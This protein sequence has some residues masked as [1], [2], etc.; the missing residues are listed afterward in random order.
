MATKIF[1]GNVGGGKSYAAVQEVMSCLSQGG[2]VATNL[3]L[4]W[5]TIDAQ[6]P[7]WKSRITKLPRKLTS[8]VKMAME[9]DPET[10]EDIEVFQ[11][12][13]ATR[14]TEG[15][16]NLIVIDEASL[17]LN[18]DD[19]ASKKDE[20]KPLF[21][22]SA[23]CRHGGLDL[24]YISQSKAN[25]D[26]KIRRM[27]DRVINCVSVKR[28]PLV[29]WFLVRFGDFI[30]FHYEKDDPKPF[31]RSWHRF[32]KKVGDF[33]F[34]HGMA[35][36]LKLKEAEGVRRKPE[37]AD[38]KRGKMLFAGVALLL[39]VLGWYIWHNTTDIYA[40]RFG[41]EKPSEKPSAVASDDKKTP[42]VKSEVSKS[43]STV[44]KLPAVLGLPK[45]VHD[46]PY[47]SVVWSGPVARKVFLGDGSRLE[48]GASWRGQKVL[49]LLTDADLIFVALS[50]GFKLCC[51]PFSREEIEERRPKPAAKVGL[52]EGFAN[53]LGINPNEPTK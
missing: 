37:D 10:G 16:E 8:M 2:Y 24:I 46:V 12:P 18:V 43:A 41:D 28:I 40:R 42:V 50:G 44:G 38:Q 21:A 23:L 53:A 7:D 48:I 20:K 25:L 29:G 35:N 49:A 13:Y 19:Q 34:T 30:R 1:T 17:Q 47:S 32:D 6:Y 36:T 45:E 14:G 9:R 33:Y 31:D 11:C 27:A 39:C 5:D 52:G 22:L 4:N 3:P 51:R 15:A 26:V